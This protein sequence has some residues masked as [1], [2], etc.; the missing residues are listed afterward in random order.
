MTAHAAEPD[1]VYETVAAECGIDPATVLAELRDAT[2]APLPV[3][4]AR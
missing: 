3:E 4:G 2:A 1:H